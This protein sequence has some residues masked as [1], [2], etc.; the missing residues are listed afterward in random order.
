MKNDIVPTL[1]VFQLL[2]KEGYTQTQVVSV[3]EYFM[4]PK[5]VTGR[6][7]RKDKVCGLI[8]VGWG[9]AFFM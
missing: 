4:Y 1:V 6:Q 8:G 7:K 2:H 5:T 9:D 3:I